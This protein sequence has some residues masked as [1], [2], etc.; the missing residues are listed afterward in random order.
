MAIGIFLGG[1]SLTAADKGCLMSRVSLHH[2]LLDRGNRLGRIEALGTGARAVH[3]SVAAVQLELAFQIVQARTG[4]LVA[5][6]EDPAI[7]LQQNRRTEVLVTVPPVARAT[8]R[9]AG[10]QLDTTASNMRL[11]CLGASR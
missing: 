5:R 9:A 6:V 4:I 1:A 7:G 11:A 8:R 10:A 3:D 2:Q